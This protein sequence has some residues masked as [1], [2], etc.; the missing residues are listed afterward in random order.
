MGDKTMK[1]VKKTG[2][3]MSAITLVVAEA[4]LAHASPTRGGD[5]SVSA[6]TTN[7]VTRGS[8]NQVEIIKPSKKLLLRCPKGW[9]IDYA[10]QTVYGCKMDLGPSIGGRSDL[11]KWHEI[12]PLLDIAQKTACQSPHYWNDGPHLLN[13]PGNGL[14]WECRHK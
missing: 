8:I 5:V 13:S 10:S 2:I 9:K 11:G 6:Q 3:L 14:R 7:R 1:S 4:S 12:G